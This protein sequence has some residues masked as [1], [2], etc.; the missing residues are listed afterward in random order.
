MNGPDVLSSRLA[1]STTGKAD[2]VDLLTAVA[3]LQTE[4]LHAFDPGQ[5]L[6]WASW[7][8]AQCGRP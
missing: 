4:E 2:L 5:R 3:L 7:D 6:E 1:R 8:R